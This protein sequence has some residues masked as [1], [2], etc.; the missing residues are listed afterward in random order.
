LFAPASGRSQSDSGGVSLVLT[1][2]GGVSAKLRIGAQTISLT[3][4]LNADGF[5]QLTS[6]ARG[7]AAL[8]ATVQMDF[9]A[10]SFSGI[11]SNNAAG[12]VISDLNGYKEIYS[13]RN[14]TTN[15][16]GR[17]SLIIPGATNPAT[18]PYGSSFG[19]AQVKTSGILTFTGSLADGTP[20]S[21]SSAVLAGG[22]WP[23][24]LPLYSGKG[25]LL[26]WIFLTNGALSSSPYAS[27]INP[28][29]LNKNAFYRS[30]FTNQDA[31][32]S[33][34]ALVPENQPLLYLTNAVLVLGGGGLP[35]I[36]TNQLT[37]S[38]FQ[39]VIFTDAA[40]TMS[41][42]LNPTTGLIYGVLRNAAISPLPVTVNGIL[43]PTN[44]AGYFEGVGVSGAFTLKSD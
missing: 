32:I 37:E 21:Q 4:K 41:F 25:S 27:W 1:K 36:V 29:N 5:G 10:Q 35:A 13:A 34:G 30:G 6:K 9:A 23:L 12:G 16:T 39:K 43:G 38:S 42:T 15:Y 26:S 17:Y 28:T 3:G 20:V 33:G 44:A 7:A 8:T 40:N 24:Y 2:T 22:Y 18:G 19:A 11:V 14:P 31:I